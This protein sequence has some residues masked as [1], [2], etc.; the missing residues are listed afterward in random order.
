MFESSQAIGIVVNEM[1]LSELHML[2]RCS[3]HFSAFDKTSLIN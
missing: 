3:L 2:R 1:K